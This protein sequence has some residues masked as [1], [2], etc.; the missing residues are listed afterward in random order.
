MPGAAKEGKKILDK[1]EEYAKKRNKGMAHD[2]LHFPYQPYEEQEAEKTLRLKQ[3]LI[4]SRA[5]EHSTAGRDNVRVQDVIDEKEMNIWIQKSEE[6]QLL[7]FD[8]FIEQNYLQ[9]NE[10]YNQKLIRELY[11]EYYER[12]LKLIDQHTAI[13]RELAH[14][15]LYG[16]PRSKEDL[17]LLYLLSTNQISVPD[18]VAFDTTREDDARIYLRG[19]LNAKTLFPERLLRTRPA[20]GQFG[21][22]TFAI[23]NGDGRAVQSSGAIGEISRGFIREG[24]GY[25]GGKLGLTDGVSRRANANNNAS[26]QGGNRYYNNMF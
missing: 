24:P 14:M 23:V 10:L 17:R 2:D 4:A 20:L 26:I 19:Y 6:S 3:A 12:R 1:R 18:K 7:D 16:G 21:V 25:L 22:N 8:A 13:Q 5:Y 11:P 9:G 15:K